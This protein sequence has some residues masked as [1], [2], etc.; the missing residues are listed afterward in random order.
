[1][2][3]IKFQLCLK[4]Y[5]M[6][7]WCKDALNWIELL[8]LL[9]NTFIHLIFHGKLNYSWKR[10]FKTLLSLNVYCKALSSFILSISFTIAMP[11][12]FKINCHTQNGMKINFILVHISCEWWWRC[13]KCCKN[14]LA[15][16]ILTTL[17]NKIRWKDKKFIFRL[18]HWGF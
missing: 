17:K 13:V 4:Y 5:C 15:C 16:D 7:F 1:M 3:Q 8:S 12:Y 6:S 9:H 14:L 10:I 2:H 18:I 11:D